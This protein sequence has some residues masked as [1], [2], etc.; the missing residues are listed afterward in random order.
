[1]TDAR[2]PTP[3]DEQCETGREAVAYRGHSIPVTLDMVMEAKRLEQA[4]ERFYPIEI[5]RVL[6]ADPSALSEREAVGDPMENWL[7]KPALE[8]LEQAEHCDN[9][10]RCKRIAALLR[11]L[12]RNQLPRSEI[13]EPKHPEVE[14]AK[15]LASYLEGYG[16]GLEDM[17]VRDTAVAIIEALRPKTLSEVYGNPKR[18]GSKENPNV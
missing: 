13:E 11:D 16:I 12:W 3:S 17:I 8:W 6:Y 9:N 7:M 2:I 10:D 1:M 14:K 15:G 18:Q 5:G 4:G